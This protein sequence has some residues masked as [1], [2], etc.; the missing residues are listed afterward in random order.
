[1]TERRFQQTMLS[2]KKS[3]D[4]EDIGRDKSK[5]IPPPHSWFGKDGNRDEIELDEND[6]STYEERQI[7]DK[8]TNDN[9]SFSIGCNEEISSIQKSY[10]VGDISDIAA[11]GAPRKSPSWR[12][13]SSQ[14]LPTA[15][16]E[17][18]ST[19]IYRLIHAARLTYAKGRWKRDYS[20]LGNPYIGYFRGD[21]LCLPSFS[22]LPWVDR[23]LVREWRTIGQAGDDDDEEFNRARTLVPEI[24]QRQPWK[25]RENCFVCRKPFGP[26]LLRHHCRMCGNS[27]CHEHS[28][29]SHPLHHLGYDPNVPERVCLECKTNLSEQNLSERIAVSY[30]DECNTES[31][32]TIESLTKFNFS[33]D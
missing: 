30:N 32:F 22:S 6:N 33:G 20:D 17:L 1:M 29:Q 31:T 10:I 8:A 5:F 9:Q 12:E 2:L 18:L 4:E 14:V 24:M 11:V 15:A 3:I 16:K 19:S 21:D 25:K 27:F 26:A 7:D 23:Q 13:L 28:R